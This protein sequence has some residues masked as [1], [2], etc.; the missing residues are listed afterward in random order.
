MNTLLLSLLLISSAFAKPAGYK[1]SLDDSP[2]IRKVTSISE[3]FDAVISD[4]DYHLN[5]IQPPLNHRPAVASENKYV[6]SVRAKHSKDQV[7]KFVKKL[8]SLVRAENPTWTRSKAT[9]LL[10]TIQSHLDA[11]VPEYR[12]GTVGLHHWFRDDAKDRRMEAI[13]NAIVVAASF[14]APAPSYCERSLN[15]KLENIWRDLIR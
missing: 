14:A 10:E 7:I 4:L 8:N 6:E 2:I 1:P 3:K 15:S 9:K 13:R 12:D 11:I 5:E